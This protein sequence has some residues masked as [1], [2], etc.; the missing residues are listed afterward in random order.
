MSSPPDH[1]VV[2]GDVLGFRDLVLTHK[3]V[4]ADTLTYRRQNARLMVASLEHGN[5]LQRRL[6]NFHLK[7]D[8]AVFNTKWP[9][10]VSVMV[11]SDSLFLAT[12]DG[13]SCM[14]FCQR[15]LTECLAADIP[16]RMG[17]GYGSF[18]SNSFAF[19][20]V[21]LA[22]VINTQF[23]GTAVVYANDAE[24]ALK[25]LRIALHPSSVE[26]LGHL[27]LRYDRRLPLPS[28][29]V[30]EHVSHEWNILPS[31]R[32]DSGG[33]L[34]MQRE[35]LIRHVEKMRSDSLDRPDIQL[36]YSRTLSAI[37]QMMFQTHQEWLKPG[38]RT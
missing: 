28:E 10:E 35:A 23:L 33:G 32:N 9:A 8:E 15:L 27:Q 29:Q 20:S 1:F 30:N 19:E 12:T 7:V 26:P 6:K 18:I 22:R 25:G 31:E 36:H 38:V 11:F 14:E 24:K 5:P 4:Q 21:P 13:K 3:T 17:V 34:R 16:L 2:Y 37:Q